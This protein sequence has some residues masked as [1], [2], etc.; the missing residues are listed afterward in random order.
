MKLQ[1]LINVGLM[2]LDCYISF[3]VEDCTV[4]I[5]GHILY[6]KKKRKSN[7]P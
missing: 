7:F 6:F 2:C 1:S 5:L 3:S 4:F